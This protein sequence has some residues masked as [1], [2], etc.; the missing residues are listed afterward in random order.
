LK[1][2]MGGYYEG[3]MLRLAHEPDG[4]F[5]RDKIVADFWVR[6]A[7]K[8]LLGENGSRSHWNRRPGRR[9]PQ[10]GI[11]DQDMIYVSSSERSIPLPSNHV[12]LMFTMNAMDHVSRFST[13]A[14]EAVRVIT[15]GWTV[16]RCVQ[17]RGASNIFRAAEAHGRSRSQNGLAFLC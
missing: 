9:L 5:L 17:S 14:A 12:D 3:T 7:R 13:T 10:F 4:E 1:K 8:P 2:R 16:H 11:H 15:P 6:S